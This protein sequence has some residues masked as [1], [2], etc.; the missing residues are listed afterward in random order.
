MELGKLS[1]F[2][3]AKYLF[4]TQQ[5]KYRE[6][7]F[8]FRKLKYNLYSLQTINDVLCTFTLCHHTHHSLQ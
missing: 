5:E 1:I 2:K 3:K 4:Q 8:F 6:F 7:G